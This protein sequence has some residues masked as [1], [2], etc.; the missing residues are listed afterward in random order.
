MGG[1]VPDDA[2]DVSGKKAPLDWVGRYLMFENRNPT[3]VVTLQFPV[4]ETTAR[5][6]V[7]A[8]TPHEKIY[9]C[10]FRGSTLVNI[11]PRDEHPTSYRF[12]LRDEMRRDKTPMKKVTR[13][14]CDRLIRDW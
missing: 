6:T 5:Y 3:D 2:V 1:I 12:Y 8:Q 9:T 13:F 4:R 7:N 11:S 10:T 14:V